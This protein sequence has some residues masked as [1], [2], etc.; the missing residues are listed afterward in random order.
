MAT[1]ILFRSPIAVHAYQGPSSSARTRRG[2]G[3]LHLIDSG[4]IYGIERMLLAL[5]PALKSSGYDVAL[6]CFGS[7]GTAGGAVGDAMAALGV[8]TYFFD[9]ELHGPIHGVATL[10]R[11][12][13]D[14]RWAV[15]HTHGYK[16]TILAGTIGRCLRRKVVTTYHGEAF[17][18]V[19]LDR[20]IAI[21]TR[22]IRHVQHVVAVSDAIAAEL[23][24]RGVSQNSV[25]VIPNGIPSQTPAARSGRDR[26]TI[27]IVG[28]L[29]REKNVHVALAAI[30][31]LR[32][33]WP[34]LRAVIAGEG[35]FL[36][37]LE[38]QVG[39]LDLQGSVEFCGFVED[40]QGLLADADIF[41]MPSQT[42]GMPIA[43]L[44]AMASGLPIVA[45]AVGSIPQVARHGKEA[46]LVG[47]GDG[48]ALKSAIASLLEQ[49]ALADRLASSARARFTSHFT[50]E[51]MAARYSSMYDHLAPITSP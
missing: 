20:H 22:V 12:L 8:P 6:G 43:L 5:L 9:F 19:G 45:S 15:V 42:E 28:R 1:K 26:R 18:A 13:L 21:E 29:I 30:A 49:P 51:S 11:R 31:A 38:A 2:R 25:E 40:V 16:A 35:P 41:V 34:D 27:A 23:V 3:I 7:S 37:E 32:V 17:K 46:V 48:P 10:T 14:S 33:R 50:S 4:G 39:S 24:Q 47:P 44:E 36:K